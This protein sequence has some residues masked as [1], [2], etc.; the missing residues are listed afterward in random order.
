MSS[1]NHDRQLAGVPK[2]FKRRFKIHYQVVRTIDLDHII[3]VGILLSLPSM[4]VVSAIS[5]EAASD[6]AAPTKAPQS[7]GTSADSLYAPAS[8]VLSDS[9][10]IQIES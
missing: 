8:P 3:G 10:T 5:T 6:P 9:G 1:L 7:V 2:M 4:S